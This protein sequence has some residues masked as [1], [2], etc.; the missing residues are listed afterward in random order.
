MAQIPSSPVKNLEDLV[1]RMTD[2]IRR[3]LEL[4]DI[5]E[6]TVDELRRVLNVD[7]VKVYQFHEDASGEVVAEA[8]QK[9]RL[10]SLLGQRFPAGDIPEEAREQF[11]TVRQRSIVNIARHEIGTSPLANEPSQDPAMA[12]IAFRAV[13][14]CHIEYLTAMGVQ[15]SLVVPI[16]HHHKLWGLL[17]AHHSVPRRFGHKELEIVQLIADQVT[18]A[19]AHASLLQ[20]TRAQG[21]HESIINQTVSHLHATGNYPLR[22]ALAQMV[23]ALQCIG[24]RLFILEDYPSAAFRLIADGKQPEPLKSSSGGGLQSSNVLTSDAITPKALTLEQ[25]AEWQN[26]LK[27]EADSQIVANLWAIA[28]IENFSV[29]SPVVSAFSHHH[30]KGVLVAKLVHQNRFLG[31]LSLFREAVDIE[32]IWAGQ[33]DTSDPRQQRPRESFEAWRELKKNQAQPWLPH[34]I[35]LAQDLADR[36]ASVIYQMQLNESLQTLNASLEARVVQ[37]TAQ[38]EQLNESLKQEI[39]ERER[40]F[41][42]LQV[43]RDALKRLAH[44]N[45][46]I[47]NSAGEGIYG[48]DPKGKIVVT[49]QAEI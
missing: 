9:Q 17:V 21:Q 24:G 28:D 6:A 14:P 10:P 36:F 39:K 43:A 2:R 5:L 41:R 29:D 44:Q 13:D 1:H 3:S 34:E 23:N 42:E 20:L 48:I 25:Q 33:H 7:R 30:I 32:T 8:I 49:T 38:L 45:E 31:Y 18:V 26:W 37:R 11:F 12:D 16:L 4:P 35:G 19:I 27:G 15:A 46:L 47:L 40:A 22:N